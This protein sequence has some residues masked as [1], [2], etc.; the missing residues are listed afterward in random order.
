MARV[1]VSDA[2]WVEFRSACLF[3]GEHVAEAL[4]RLVE[5]E[6]RRKA[7]RPTTASHRPQA[8]RPMAPTL[9]DDTMH[10]GT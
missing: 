10:E 5:G 3:E 1:N 6:L 8:S 7:R 4:G 9:F 2:V